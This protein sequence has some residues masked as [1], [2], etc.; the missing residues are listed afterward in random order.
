MEKE[1]EKNEIFSA[2]PLLDFRLKH[3]SLKE[4]LLILKDGPDI[5]DVQ[6]KSVPLYLFT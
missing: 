2:E 6:K 5:I 3:F 4:S 1:D